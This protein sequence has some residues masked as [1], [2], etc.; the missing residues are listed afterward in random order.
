MSQEPS[1][2]HAPARRARTAPVRSNRTEVAHLWDEL[3]EDWRAAF[4][5]FVAYLQ[6]E[7]GLS[8]RTIESYRRDW[9]RFAGFVRGYERNGGPA[10]G[11]SRRTIGSHPAL[12]PR[13]DANPAQ[14]PTSAAIGPT[15]PTPALI[16]AYP[17]HL[18]AGGYRASSA[19]RH[20]AT[21]RA[22]LRWLRQTQQVADDLT[23]LLESPK[24]GRPLPKTLSAASTARLVAA[25]ER[26]SAL[27]LRDRAI[28]ELFYAS[29]LRVSELCSLRMMDVHLQVGYVR[30]LGKG[31]R[32][33]VVPFGR[34]ARDALEAYLEHQR[35][36]LLDRAV[37]RG[38]VRL[39]ISARALAQQPLFLSRSGGSIERTAVWRLVQRESRRAGVASRVSPHTLRHSFATHLLE[40]GADL[41]IVQ[42]LL[43]HASV[44]TTEIY[45]HVQT[46]RLKE[47][48]ERCHPHGKATPSRA[49]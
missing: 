47:L 23:A 7:C 48:H 27:G 28:L 3:P 8:P 29:G 30:C 6:A 24:R 14:K 9:L 37:A 10:S 31:N 32:E 13:T 36:A 33:R 21:L 45:T 46:R 11:P 25:P 20:L 19:A 5:R 15:C 49:K 35:P 34:Q 42:E 1:H 40:G 41:R 26:S 44:A 22:W 39:P 2:R 4:D 17:V 43:G 12:P 38:R 16:R 18:A